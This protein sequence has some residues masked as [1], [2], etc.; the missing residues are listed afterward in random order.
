[1]TTTAA[2]IVAAGRGTRAGGGLPK[3]W[4]PLAGQRVIDHVVD[5]FAGCG[6][7]DRICIVVHPDDVDRADGFRQAGHMVVTGAGTRSGSVRA[8]L[9]ALADDAPDRV[10]IHDAA[11]PCISAALIGAV[12]DALADAPG[13]APALAVTDALWTGD[14]GRV[15]G[16]RDRTGL[17]RAQTPQG[18]RFDAI[19]QAHRTHPAEA[20]DDVEVARA[21]GLDVSIVPGE[22]RNLKVTHPADFARAEQ[23]L[24]G[25]AP[26]QAAAGLEPD[27][28]P[29]DQMD[30]RTGNGFDVHR[31]GPGDHVTLCGVT[32]PHD[33]GLQGHSDADVGM[34]AVTDAIYG[35]LARGDIGQHFP[36]SDPRWKG[37]ESHI[38]LRH[39]V[40]LAAAMGFVITHADC[41]LICE[42]PKIGPHAPAM[43]AEMA[44]IMGL[45]PDR[46]SVKATTSER[47]GFTGRGEGIAALATATL[48]KT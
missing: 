6:R 11:R 13:A 2:L 17:F 32:I 9:M 48:V 19:L 27:H 46:V 26:E 24:L 40:E 45:D 4:R 10:L 29:G 20:A 1:M 21:A 23:I 31:F 25:G 34:H 42:Y 33:R 12:D 44:R 14:A 7:I 22:E 16:T 18:F 39:A 5:A 15:T 35:A 43:R 36:P 8:G 30:I 38:F 28:A 3:Q 47:L 37:A 41:T